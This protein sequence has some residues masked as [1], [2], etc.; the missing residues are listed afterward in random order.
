MASPTPFEKPQASPPPE[1]GPRE[2]SRLEILQGLRISTWEGSFSTIHAT[3]TTGAFLTGFALWLGA[4][5][6]VMGLITAIPTLA[7][8]I[9]IVASYLAERQPER[10]KF[11]AWTATLGRTLWLGILLLPLFLPHSA[12][13]AGFLVL[14]T[15][16]F[17]LLNIPVPAWTSWMS[18]LVPPDNRGRYFARRNRIAGIVGMVVG[19]PAAEFL[20]LTTKRHAWNTLGFGALF[21]AAVL[22]GLASFACL[23]RQPEPPRR[24]PP[25]AESP[26]GWAGVLAYYRAPFAD[27]NFR[28]LMAFNTL[29]GVGQFFAAPFFN[30]Y[31]LQVLRLDYMWLQI[32][33]TLSSLVTL[34]CLPLWG[35]FSDKMGNRALLV[36]GVCGVFSLPL[37]WMLTT[38]RNP[39][40]TLLLLTEINIGS[41]LFWAVVSLTQFN[42]LISLS[43]P[44]R[45]SGYVASM[46]AVTGLAG[47][48]APLLGGVL[49]R[50]LA[51]W[52]ATLFGLPLLN[53]HA[54]FFLSA[55]LRIGALPLLKGFSEPESLSPRA[56]LVQMRHAHPRS[57]R[58]IRQLQGGSEQA[59]MEATEALAEERNLLAAGELEM[60]LND[61]SAAVRREAARALGQ[62]EGLRSLEPL[63]A[64][65]RDPSPEVVEEAVR[66]LG[67]IGDRQANP[68]LIALLRDPTGTPSVRIRAVAASAL[69]RLGGADA[70]EALLA[71]LAEEPAG[72]LAEVVVHAL[73]EIGDRRA[74]PALAARLRAPETSTGLRLALIE[75]LGRLGNHRAQEALR[76]LLT[77]PDQPAALI[78]ALAEAL[79]RLEDR[80]ALL[81]LLDRMEDLE[82]PIARRQV[83]HAIGLLLGQGETV[84]HLLSRD[85]FARDELVAK[86]IGE[87]QRSSRSAS[88]RRTLRVALQAYTE[89][90]Y[91]ATLR[92][93]ERVARTLSSRIAP[94]ATP[95]DLQRIEYRLLA[96]LAGQH[97]VSPSLESALIALAAL[98]GLAART[99]QS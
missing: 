12:A 97:R 77:D 36:I 37:S 5:N 45:T 71:V 86:L 20:D 24:I 43:P 81:P 34:A 74:L 42:L 56:A 41:G 29:F 46:A 57:L 8:L 88:A 87:M 69:G 70:D 89:G 67:Q 64:A 90:E 30:V 13:L 39:G 94:G 79:A 27:A 49:M 23:M 55:L 47:G 68:A 32:F 82:A 9:Q 48:I 75:S 93:L 84:Y 50:G 96:H 15:L 65:L 17:V 80:E 98:Y 31:A 6:L 85:A 95:V 53:F 61:P 63:L 11:T 16:S 1:N 52:H 78:P 60:A 4:N 22:A 83:A 25:S 40:L 3:L 62:I 54:A 26:G 59:R 35:Y 51:G 76:A 10:K 33:A 58:H 72:G 38:P 14:Y 18:D 66:A 44:E 91:A 73:G 7:G 28:R 92:A 19:L 21:G 99:S 2:L